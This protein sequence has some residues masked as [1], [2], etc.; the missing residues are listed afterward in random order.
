MRRDRCR[1]ARAGRGPDRACR[2]GGRTCRHRHARWHVR[3]SGRRHRRE[4]QQRQRRAGRRRAAC[5]VE[6]SRSWSSTPPT[7]RRWSLRC[8]LVIDAAYGTG[9]RGS[10]TGPDVGAAPV[11]AV[12]IPSGVDGLT[13]AATD[14]V[15]HAERTVTFAALKPGLLLAPGASYAGQVEV[16]DIGLDVS[17]ARAHLVERADVAG[18]LPARQPDAHKWKASVRIV[19]GSA[20]MLGAAHLASSAAQRAGAG[21]VRLSSPGVDHDPLIPTEVVGTS[22]PSSGWVSLVLDDLD[23]FG[24]LVVGPGLGRADATAMAVPRPRRPQRPTGRGRRRRPVRDGVGT[25]GPAVAARPDRADD[26]HPA[27]RR[28]PHAH[29]PRTGSRPLRRRPAAGARDG[30]GRPA[31]GSDDDRRRPGRQ[32]ARQHRRRRAP[33]DRRHRRRARRDHRRAVRT[34]RCGLRSGRGRRVA[35]RFGRLPRSA[36]RARRQ[37]RG[38]PPPA[39]CWSRS[40]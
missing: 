6:G 20:G 16:V 31:E 34:G 5:A 27:R 32:G 17:T 2:R 15:L 21:M 19:A 7:R 3:A 26:P 8:D 28:V 18:W 37:R 39:R 10:W 13:G 23:R 22:L 9:F 24:A 11:L 4:G 14:G 40:S 30:R 29:R 12:D 36:P 1:R 38:R 25:G 35:A 33:R